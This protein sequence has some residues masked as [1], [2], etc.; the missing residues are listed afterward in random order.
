M[1]QGLV[2]LLHMAAELDWL[3]GLLPTGKCL[4]HVFQP[5]VIVEVK[6]QVDALDHVGK[7]SPADPGL[8]DAHGNPANYIR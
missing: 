8:D 7:L 2:T 1:I 4:V 3:I 6:V 5:G